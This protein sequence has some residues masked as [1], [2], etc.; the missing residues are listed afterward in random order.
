MTDES[1]NNN[2]RLLT[3][4]E[5]DQLLSAFFH[6]EVPQALNNLPS[7]WPELN[8]PQDKLRTSPKLA[9]AS[10]DSVQP[11]PTVSRGI[12]VAVATLAACLMLIV[13]SNVDSQPGPPDTAESVVE[14][15]N[16]DEKLMNV[17][18]GGSDGALDENQTNLIEIDQI[19]LSPPK[20]PA[21]KKSVE[22]P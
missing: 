7:T 17:S 18:D 13:F 6:A 4:S 12:A 1:K 14:P 19:D 22:T 21:E 11:A 3:E 9:M 8:R 15:V 16:P 5:M 20:V 2:G 10:T